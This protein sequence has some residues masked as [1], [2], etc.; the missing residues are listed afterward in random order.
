MQTYLH[1]WRQITGI[2]SLM[3]ACLA[4]TEWIEVLAVGSREHATTDD[5]R[6]WEPAIASI[7]LTLISGYLILW[8][9]RRRPPNA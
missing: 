5:S 9:P 7:T 8:K 2:V 3:L 1:G 4:A 6:L